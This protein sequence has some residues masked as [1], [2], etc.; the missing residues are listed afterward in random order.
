MV[1]AFLDLILSDGLLVWPNI[2]YNGSLVS[3]FAARVCITKIEDETTNWKT[4]Q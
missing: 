3:W 4:D 1:N 2:S